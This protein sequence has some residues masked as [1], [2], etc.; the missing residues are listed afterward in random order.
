MASIAFLGLG[1]MGSR[2]AAN[3]IK[4]GHRVTAWSRDDAKSAPLAALGAEI[5]SSP[6]AA[7]MASDM[8]I[9]MVRDDEASRQIWLHA[10]T[11]AFAGMRRASLAI[12]C[13]TLSIGT[14]ET[15]AGEAKARGLAF[16]D[17]PV[18]GS[19][20]QAEAGQ[21]IFMVGGDGDSLARAEPVL[22]A[23]GG[24]I[25]HAGPNGAGAAVKL[26]VNA[27]FG[28]QIAA[29]AEIIGWLHAHG[30]APATASEIIAATP[31]AS[32]AAKA[33]S[34]SMLAGAFA[35]LFPVELVEKDFGYVTLAAGLSP[36]GA[37]MAGAARAVLQRAIAAGLGADNLT[38]I[39]RL[40]TGKALA[41]I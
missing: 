37:P 36:G 8:V 4:G 32:P 7:A 26:G 39:V 13:S 14:V 5:A 31:V 2:M 15:L 1:A 38:G 9:A 30:V 34:Q 20:P 19:R 3:L 41:G 35:P 27:L 16:L 25:H 28:I 29:L 40:Y 21:L 6:K 12:E 11:G 33:A 23:M 24:A 18:A 10:E 17:A 22:L